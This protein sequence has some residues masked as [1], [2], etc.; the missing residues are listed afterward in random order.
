MHESRKQQLLQIVTELISEGDSVAATKFHTEIIGSATFV[1]LQAM[2]KWFG[3]VKSLGHLLGTAARPW[4]ELLTTDPD[5][6]TLTFTKRILGTLQAI[7]H[8]LEHDHLKNFTQ[9]VK[10]ETLADLL[11]QAQQLLNAGYYLAAGVIGRAVLEEHLRST[12]DLVGCFP[13]KQRP[14][15]HDY[16]QALYGKEHYSKTKMKLI[17]GLTS[18]GNDA[19]HNKPELDARDVKKLIQDLPGVIE[20]TGI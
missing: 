20:S 9:L 4:R 5:L 8:E 17:E 3:K 6:N 19:A 10:A 11:D 16:N 1:D 12:C 18:I 14:T 15:V 2:H 13:S 7:Q